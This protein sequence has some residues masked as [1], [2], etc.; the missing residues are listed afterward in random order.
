M[1]METGLGNMA[2]T[3]TLI[4]VVP[5]HSK[6]ECL[7]RVSTGKRVIKCKQENK[8]TL[9]DFAIKEKREMRQGLGVKGVREGVCR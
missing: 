3:V 9:K 6:E 1:R 4:R 5:G 8:H 7:L 2:Y